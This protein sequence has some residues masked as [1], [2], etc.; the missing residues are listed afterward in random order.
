MPKIIFAFVAIIRDVV[1]TRAAEFEKLEVA[2]D[3]PRETEAD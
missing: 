2:V 1:R 3:E